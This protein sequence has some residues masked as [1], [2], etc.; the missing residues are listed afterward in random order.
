MNITTLNDRLSSFVNRYNVSFLEAS[1]G[2]SR[3]EAA[4]ACRLLQFIRSMDEG[5]DFKLVQVCELSGASR[6][7]AHKAPVALRGAGHDYMRDI[8]YV[9]S[10]PRKPA[11]LIYRRRTPGQKAQNHAPP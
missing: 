10:Q 5:D 6:R 11:H 7:Y 2:L 3:P 8:D 4:A 1:T 9:E